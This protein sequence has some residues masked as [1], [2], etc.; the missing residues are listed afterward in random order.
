MS[1]TPQP[2]T[3]ALE[4]AGP[5][6]QPFISIHDD[7]AEALDTIKDQVGFQFSLYDRNCLSS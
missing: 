7:L 6:L 5:A 4:K 3:P 1:H 2:H